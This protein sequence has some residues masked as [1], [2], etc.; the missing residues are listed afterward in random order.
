V[1]GGEAGRFVV[2]G[3]L[4]AA[5][6]W[7][8]R[9]ALSSTMSFALATLLAYAIGMVVGFL[10]YRWF[11][12]AAAGT[13]LRRQIGAF[14]VVN[15]AGALVVVAVASGLVALLTRGA[16]DLPLRVVEAGAHALAIAIGALCNFAGHKFLTFA[17]PTPALETQ[18]R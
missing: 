16:P 2:A 7:L 11:V 9:I 3:G 12:F 17:R 18:S 14:L 15:A 4:A 8:A 6:N 1:I 13:P 5:I 10:L